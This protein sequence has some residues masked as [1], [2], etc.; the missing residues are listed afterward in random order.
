MIASGGGKRR[1]WEPSRGGG[2]LVGVGADIQRHGTD[3][4]LDAGGEG[5]QQPRNGRDDPQPA[6]RRCT[7]RV[8]CF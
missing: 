1:A 3:Q 4:D 7:H 8:I 5:V 2:E 6:P